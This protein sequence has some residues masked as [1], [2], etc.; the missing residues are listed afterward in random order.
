MLYCNEQAVYF[1]EVREMPGKVQKSF[2]RTEKK[3]LLQRETYE[4]LRRE[5]APY[6]EEDSYGLSLIMSLYYDT[7]HFDMIRHSLEKPAYKEKL[8]L[9]SYGVPK[10]DDPV[11]LEI[12]KKSEGVVYKRRVTLSA[13]EAADYLAGGEKPAGKGQIMEEIDWM[14]RRYQPKPAAVI[15]TNRLALFGKEDSALRLTFDFEPRGRLDELDLRLG[16]RGE[17]LLPDG[18]VLMELKVAGAAPLWLAEILSRMRIYP[19]SF[20]K[21]GTCYRRELARSVTKEDF[22][23]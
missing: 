20:S 14:R 2:Q 23:V 15:S 9:R 17:A 7:E 16:D 10:D 6:M 3:Y 5:L 21:Y 4:A 8:R 11:F 18:M 12:K 22:H 1:E 13:K 19:R